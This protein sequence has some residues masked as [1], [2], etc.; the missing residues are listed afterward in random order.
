MTYVCYLLLTLNITI[1][2]KE[3]IEHFVFKCM[4]DHYIDTSVQFFYF[5][6]ICY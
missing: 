4:Y 1:V 2:T 3:F 6:A 5:M